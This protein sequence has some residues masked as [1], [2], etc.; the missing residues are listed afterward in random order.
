MNPIP[1]EARRELAKKSG[2]GDDYLYQVLTRRKP[3]SLELCIN[4]E[5]ES[6]RAITCEDLRPDIDWAYLR[7][8]A[9]ATTTEQGAGHA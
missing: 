9:K 8:T 4:L 6:Q 7:G 1:I 5:R 2:I 3:A